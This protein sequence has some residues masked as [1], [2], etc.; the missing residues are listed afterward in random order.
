MEPCLYETFYEV[1]EW[2][3]WSVGTRAIFADWLRAALPAAPVRVLDVGCGTGIFVREI[4]DHGDVTGVDVYP[5]AVA[6]G[7]RRGLER[8]CVGSAE[9]L[10]FRSGAFDVVTALDVVEHTDDRRTVAEIV[11]VLKPGGLTLIH[12]P[13]FPLL[14]GEH[15]EVNRHRRRYRRG[16]LEAILAANG[17]AVERLSYVNCI[18]F[19]AVLAVRVAKRVLRPLRA[20]RVPRPEIYDVP[21]WLNRCLVRVLAVERAVMQ[22]RISLPFG[23]SILCLARKSNS[24]GKG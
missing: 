3:W 22:R 9:R 10:P 11:R 21:R 24:P 20:D 4:A 1:E 2:Y 14:W 19:P 8:L 12:V 18:L 16:P 23:V 7:V 5:H 15:D 6:L 17:L 13:A